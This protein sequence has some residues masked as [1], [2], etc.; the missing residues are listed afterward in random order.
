MR[1]FLWSL[2]A[3][4]VARFRDAAEKLRAGFEATHTAPTVSWR[5]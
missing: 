5:S 1:Q 3:E 2:Y 4:F